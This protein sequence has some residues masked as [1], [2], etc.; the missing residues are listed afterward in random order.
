MKVKDLFMYWFVRSYMRVMHVP[1]FLGHLSAEV[2]I[3]Q[4]G[5]RRK[6]R[7]VNH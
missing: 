1:A 7:S 3:D 4:N 5:R 6:R 2:S